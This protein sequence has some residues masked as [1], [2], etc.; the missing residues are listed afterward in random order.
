M[1]PNILFI[2]HM[3]PP[4]H[5]ASMVG[6]YIHDSHVINE[7]FNCHYFNLTLAKNLNDIGKGGIRKLFDFIKQLFC[8]WK[9][10]KKVKPQLCYVTPNAKGGAFYKD[11]F[12]VMLLKLMKQN[13]VIHYHNK[14]VSTRQDKILDNFLYTHFFKRLKVILLS[15]VLY[16]DIK[17]Y[18]SKKNVFFCPNGIPNN[19]SPIKHKEANRTE[20]QILF[21]SN[22]IATKG[23][24]ELVEA[25][26]LLKESG[27]KFKCHFVGK[28]NDVTEHDFNEKIHQMGLDSYLIGHGAQYG[29][30]KIKTLQD[31]DI[32]VFPTYYPNECF[33]IVLLEA[34][35]YALPCISTNEGGIPDIIDQEKTGFIVEKK[36]A[37][38][39]AN[40]ISYLIKHAEL[41]KQMGENGYQ[42][43]LKEFTLTTF[44]KNLKD[45]LVKCC[46]TIY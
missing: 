31:A 11:F 9:K 41:R 25:C 19:Q 21:L 23:V 20:V 18:V 2:L 17:K 34:M 6:Q 22:M 38:Q 16:E 33:P 13:I 44:E 42:K 3:P 27:L 30:D 28:W 40:K 7:A 26:Y 39:L 12:I 45:I 35:E 37:S 1:T 10:V 46:N 5:G 15:E 24:W 36:N 8:I 29:E 4:V 43:F 14:G 32:F